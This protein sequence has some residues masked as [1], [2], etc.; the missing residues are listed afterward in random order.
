MTLENIVFVGKTK[1]FVKVFG[2]RVL[3]HEYYI[4]EVTCRWVKEFTFLRLSIFSLCV[5]VCVLVLRRQQIVLE[6]SH[7]GL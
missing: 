5:C 3:S 7:S 1:K 2:K 4:V 6:L